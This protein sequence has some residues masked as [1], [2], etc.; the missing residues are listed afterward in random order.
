MHLKVA[1]DWSFVETAIL[2]VDLAGTHWFFPVP[3]STHSAPID[4][5]GAMSPFFAHAESA[6]K[7]FACWLG[8]DALAM[9]F[10]GVPLSFVDG[11]VGVDVLSDSV[12]FVVVDL[13]DVFVFAEPGP[14]EFGPCLE[15]AQV[16]FLVVPEVEAFTVEHVVFVMA[17][18]VFV[19]LEDLQGQTVPP[20][21]FELTVIH[22]AVDPHPC[23]SQPTRQKGRLLQTLRQLQTASI[24][25]RLQ[26]LHRTVNVIGQK[27]PSI[28]ICF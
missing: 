4:Q 25:F 6:Y 17:I 15:S 13:P 20:P 3:H 23:C 18:V 26:V 8:D 16:V 7:L 22:V 1:V 14:F 21:V 9:S 11:A 5:V 27:G 12:S 19:V 10:A 2:V 28:I 24:H